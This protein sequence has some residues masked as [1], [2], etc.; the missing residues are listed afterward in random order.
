M[1]LSR[2]K[3]EMEGEEGVTVIAC[4]KENRTPGNPEGQRASRPGQEC[5]PS[6]RESNE[7]M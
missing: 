1:A 7:G 6:P 5:S 3:I 4:R 2:Q